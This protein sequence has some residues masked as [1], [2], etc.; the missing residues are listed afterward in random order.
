MQ[1]LLNARVRNDVRT[2]EKI[3]TCKAAVCTATVAAAAEEQTHDKGT[4][5]CITL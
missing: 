2:R 1:T 5:Y 4:A 3:S